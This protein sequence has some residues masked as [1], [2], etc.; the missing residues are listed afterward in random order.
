MNRVSSSLEKMVPAL[1]GLVFAVT[2]ED[3]VVVVAQREKLLARISGSVSVEYR[4]IYTFPDHS[5]L[6]FYT[7]E[8]SIRRGNKK[9]C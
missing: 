6:P 7:C 3:E 8:I 2:E 5:Y 1:P 4:D 9:W